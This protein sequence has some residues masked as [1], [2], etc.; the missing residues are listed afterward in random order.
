MNFSHPWMLLLL[1]IPLALGVWEWRRRGLT[2]TLPV[3][4][5]SRQSPRI[6]PPVMKCASLLPLWILALSILVL[7]GPR[8]VVRGKS[9]QEMKNVVLLLDVSGS[10]KDQLDRST[11]YDAAMACIDRFLDQCPGDSFS[12]TVFGTDVLE[13]VPLTRDHAAIKLAPPFLRPELMPDSFGGTNIGKALDSAREALK[14]KTEGDRMI[15]LITDGISSDIKDDAGRALARRL[16]DDKILVYSVL[17]LDPSML[18][19]AADLKQITEST[20][21]KMF[22]ANDQ[23]SMRETF[24]HIRSMRK[25]RL[26]PADLILIDDFR[27]LLLAAGAGLFLHV[28]ALFGL[29]YT[30]W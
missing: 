16:V 6:L 3:D 30:P 17:I 9:E 1:L 23:D 10:M 19:D 28:L 12:L 14:R 25:T 22:L 4:F 13:W 5:S 24:G 21:G 18:G 26:K 29:R 8:S 7:A 2:V 15:I 27:P 20:G 11:K